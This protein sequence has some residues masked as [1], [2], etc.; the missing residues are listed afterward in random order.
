MASGNH[1]T[2]TMSFVTSRLGCAVAFISQ[3]CTTFGRPRARYVTAPRNLRTRTR[4]PVSSTTSRRAPVMA[5]S[6]R[7]S[8]P[9]GSTQRSSF[10]RWTTATLG[11]VPP[12]TTMPPAACIGSRAMIAQTGLASSDVSK[13]DRRMKQNARVRCAIVHNVAPPAAVINR[14]WGMRRADEPRILSLSRRRG[15]HWSIGGAAISSRL[16]GPRPCVRRRGSFPIA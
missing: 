8:L 14:S 4:W 3:N 1:S 10:L 15:T 7:F 11:R 12:R 6:L 5:C 16:P 2:A 9:R 13:N